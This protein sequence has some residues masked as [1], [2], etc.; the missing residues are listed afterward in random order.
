MYVEL[1]YSCVGTVRVSRVLPEAE[2][3]HT[4]RQSGSA[5]LD[6]EILRQATQLYRS[7]QNIGQACRETKVATFL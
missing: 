4:A 2:H 5:G 6:V 7:C 3:Y 1:C